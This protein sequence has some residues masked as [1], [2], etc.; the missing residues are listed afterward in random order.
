[1]TAWEG[2][3]IRSGRRGVSWHWPRHGS[4][5]SSQVSAEKALSVPE[6]A[7]DGRPAV[8]G[9]GAGVPERY[10]GNVTR[11]RARGGLVRLD[12]DVL[13]FVAH[14]P[15]NR[16]DMGRFYLFCLILDQL[17]K[18]RVPGDLVELGVYKGSTATLVAGIARRLKRTAYLLDTFE[19][20]PPEDLEGIDEDKKMGFADTSMAQVQE[21]VGTESTVFI[22]GR[23]PDTA[24]QLPADG[25][26]SVVHIDCD[27]Y[28]PAKSALEYFY[29]RV[30]P[31]GFIIVHDYSS[32]HWNGAEHAVDEFLADK[33]EWLTPMTDQAGSAVIRKAGIRPPAPSELPRINVGQEAIKQQLVSGK[34]IA[35]GG[36]GLRFAT[37]SGW[38]GD[39][40]WG[41]WGVGMQHRLSVPLGQAVTGA[42]EVAADVHTPLVGPR[43]TREVD[44]WVGETM[45]GTWRFDLEHNRGIRTVRIPVDLARLSAVEPD[46]TVTIEFRQRTSE[47]PRELDPTIPEDRRLGIAVHQLRLQRIAQ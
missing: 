20:F 3:A 4:V 1:M 19:G 37:E 5:I 22:K 24:N 14:E 47:S 32:L 29:P 16:G 13:G 46:H 15:G 11:Y 36:G 44:I 27:L 43:V 26:Y 7:S 33:P 6:E 42:V 31:G 9:Y 40:P 30:P 2:A 21:R 28:A 23:F 35:A 45:V 18:D 41:I 39:E 17:V 38:S 34:W 12:Q 10:W 8:W 25:K